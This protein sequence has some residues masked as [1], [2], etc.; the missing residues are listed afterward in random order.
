[1]QRLERPSF[2]AAYIRH[3]AVDRRSEYKFPKLVQVNGDGPRY[4][5]T[6]DG[7]KLPSMSTVLSV[8]KGDELKEWRER[9]GEA[10]ANR[11]GNHA[12]K[13]GTK[14][15]LLAEHYLCRN[16]E[17]FQTAF[18][19]AMPDARDNWLGI[20]D[21]LDTRLQELHASEC[22]MFSR[23]L[24]IAGTTDVIGVFDEKLSVVD[25]KTSRK[26]KKREWIDSYFMQGDGYG[27]MWNELTFQLQPIE[28]IVIIIACDGLRDSQVFVEPFGSMYDRLIETRK[29]F[30]SL[31]GY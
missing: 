10:E 23:K 22:Q 14:V 13:R 27:T 5:T 11:I 4:Y 18:R 15:H 29:K 21:V 20:K 31:N 6:E 25:F 3:Q 7:M 28:Q 12:V 8:N 26:P 17:G 2:D 19:A 16:V 9:V 24:R 30:Y 1:M